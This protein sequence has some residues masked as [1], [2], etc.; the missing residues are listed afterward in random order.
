[1]NG[2]KQ[3]QG[4]ASQSAG[5]GVPSSVRSETGAREPRECPQP[6]RTAKSGCLNSGLEG[7]IRFSVVDGDQGKSA[8]HAEG[9]EEIPNAGGGCWSWQD[10]NHYGI[11]GISPGTQLRGLASLA[12]TLRVV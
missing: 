5:R 11:R 7:R 8:K 4:N 10:W 6:T 2:S 3:D 1:M 9:R 12:G